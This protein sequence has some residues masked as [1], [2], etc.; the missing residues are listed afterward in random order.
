MKKTTVMSSIRY[1]LTL[2]ADQPRR[3]DGVI[4]YFGG[5][6]SGS[7]RHVLRKKRAP[8]AGRPLARI[9]A[10]ARSA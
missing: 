1:L 7:A 8:G 5:S 6:P 10:P 2:L 3:I 9:V 4:D